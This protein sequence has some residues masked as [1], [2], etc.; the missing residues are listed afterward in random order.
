[1]ASESSKQK[2]KDAFYYIR[3]MIRFALMRLCLYPECVVYLR[4]YSNVA[5]NVK[6]NDGRYME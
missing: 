6:V 4:L 1:M 5:L 2:C 3:S